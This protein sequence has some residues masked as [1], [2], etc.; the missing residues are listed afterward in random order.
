MNGLLSE[1]EYCTG[2]HTCEA[3]VKHCQAS[4]MIYRDISELAKAMKNK[5]RSVIFLPT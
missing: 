4:C 5:R 3:A 2:C 1:Y